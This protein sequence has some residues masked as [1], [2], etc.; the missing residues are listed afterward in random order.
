MLYPVL[1]VLADSR[2]TILR[3]CKFL[4]PSPE[5]KVQGIW[6]LGW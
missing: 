5:F 2:M 1:L 3:D 4:V 6:R